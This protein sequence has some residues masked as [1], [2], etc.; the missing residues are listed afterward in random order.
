MTFHLVSGL[1]AMDKLDVKS[2]LIIAQVRLT[3]RGKQLSIYLSVYIYL[4]I[5]LSLFICL[6]IYLYILFGFGWIKKL[7][8]KNTIFDD[9]I[10]L[11]YFFYNKRIALSIN[12]GILKSSYRFQ[13]SGIFPLTVW[14]LYNRYE[15]VSTSIWKIT[16]FEIY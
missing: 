2:E 4:S 10:I 16:I 9:F 7:F 13:T 12:L 11:D 1:E 14:H 8:A 15:H 6:S 3:K 5:Y